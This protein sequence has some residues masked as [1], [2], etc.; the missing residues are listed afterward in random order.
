MHWSNRQ[1]F[2]GKSCMFNTRY[3]WEKRWWPESS[4]DYLALCVPVLGCE[5]E[6]MTHV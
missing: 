1:L 2:S 6:L 4:L 5:Q 3:N